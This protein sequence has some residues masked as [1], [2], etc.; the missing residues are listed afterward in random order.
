MG[1]SIMTD[2]LGLMKQK[3]VQKQAQKLST[4]FILQNTSNWYL[5]A[6]DN[7][8]VEIIHLILQKITRAKD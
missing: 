8:M 2:S 4:E 7:S 1:M 6:T 5:S 3:L